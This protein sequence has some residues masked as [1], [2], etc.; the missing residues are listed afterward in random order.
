MRKM[1]LF[2]VF[3]LVAV[4]FFPAFLDA[5]LTAKEEIVSLAEPL[6]LKLRYKV[7]E[8]LFYRLTR[9]NLNFR[10]D[11]TKFMEQ[12]VI[13][14]FTRTRLE[15]DSLG[16]VQEKFTW[17]GFWLGQTMAP[18]PLKMA[19]FKEGEDFSF[20][21]SVNDADAIRR[22]DFSSLPRTFDAFFF[23][24]LTWDAVTFDGL[25]RPTQHL[26]IPDQARLGTEFRDTQGPSDLLFSFPPLVSDSKYT[27]SGK[28]WVKVMGVSRVK[29]LPC[30]VLESANLE[31][32]VEMN[33]HI[34]PLD[35]ATR[36]FEHFWAKT[37]LSLE[38]G[39]VVRG[40]LVGPVAMTQDISR[41]GLEKPEHM[42]FLVLGYMDMDLLSPEEFEA[43]LA[44]TR[45]ESEVQ[46]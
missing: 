43:E 11:G 12:Q 42:E 7:G 4:L 15:D 28:S 10:M 46:K 34:K 5:G 38:D 27:F 36:G 8:T 19:E 35:I 40:E 22:L 32:R 41:P 13:T 25:V 16:R 44:K 14:Y 9:Q 18:Y 45:K 39:R 33:L 24:I 30:L 3:F 1:A 29:D 23:M 31:N 17:K 2:L 21:Y 20:V 6:P 37:Y 26:A